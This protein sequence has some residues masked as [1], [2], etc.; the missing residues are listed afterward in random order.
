MGP[1]S[2]QPKHTRTTQ[3]KFD[4]SIEVT[5]Y[6]PI[7]DGRHTMQIVRAILGTSKAGSTMITLQWKVVGPDDDDKGK[8][9][10]EW[11]AFKDKDGKPTQA[12]KRLVRICRAA[13]PPIV[14]NAQDPEG[15]DPEDQASVITHFLGL[16]LELDTEQEAYEYNGEER[17]QVR[18]RNL[19]RLTEA[20]A[21]ALFQEYGEAGPPLPRYALKGFDD[22]PLDVPF[23]IVDGKL[24]DGDDLSDLPF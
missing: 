3:M 6:T 15:L 14:G 13:D 18:A 23:S 16:C 10:K 9:C 24:S 22:S 20:Q 17:T 1:Q 7:A 21:E 8:T 4:T 2:P 12:V 19:Y 5:D 11:I